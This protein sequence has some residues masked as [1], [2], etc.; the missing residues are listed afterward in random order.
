MDKGPAS[1]LT[2]ALVALGIIWL[3]E[4]YPIQAPGGTL[5]ATSTDI[6]YWTTPFYLR[7]NTPVL[8]DTGHILPSQQYESWSIASYNPQGGP[9]L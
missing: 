1:L 8:D 9:P 5:P 4:H 6:D 2:L 3:F 7:N